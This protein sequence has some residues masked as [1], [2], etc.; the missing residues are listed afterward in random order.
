MRVRKDFP[1]PLSG[2]ILLRRP[3]GCPTFDS[4]LSISSALV[5]TN[6]ITCS[7]LLTDA[8]LH[9]KE[10]LLLPFTVGGDRL[11]SLIIKSSFVEIIISNLLIYIAFIVQAKNLAM[12]WSKLYRR[13]F[14]DAKRW[15]CTFP[16]ENWLNTIF[17]S[18]SFVGLLSLAILDGMPIGKNSW[19][20]WFNFLG[21]ECYSFVVLRFM[22]GPFIIPLNCAFSVVLTTLRHLQKVYERYC[23]KVHEI[24]LVSAES[25]GKETDESPTFLKITIRA[26]GETPSNLKRKIV[27]EFEEVQELFVLSEHVIS[28]LVLIILTGGTFRFVISTAKIVLRDSANFWDLV[29]LKDLAHLIIVGCHLSLLRTGQS[30]LDSVS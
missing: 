1:C 30:M 19:K 12:L 29:I 11:H 14:D 23:E 21:L 4:W 22:V 24:L 15:K 16:I 13:N 18:I 5:P 26:S 27:K 2:V 8:Y 28:P 25:L 6:I 3:W 10:E 9:F 17:V 7:V 20:S